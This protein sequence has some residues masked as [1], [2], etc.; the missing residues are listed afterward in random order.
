[1]SYTKITKAQFDE[2]QTDAGVLLRSFNPSAPSIEDS[3]I[4]CATTGGISLDITPIIED[5]SEDVYMMDA[6]TAEM[7]VLE[8][9]EVGDE[10]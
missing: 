1:M 4:I 3:D 5:L 6:H 10:G 9:W 2:M 8:G 7:A